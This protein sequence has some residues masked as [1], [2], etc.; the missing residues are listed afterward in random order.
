[1]KTII[2]ILIIGLAFF[3]GTGCGGGSGNDNAPADINGTWSGEGTITVDAQTTPITITMHFQRISGTAYHT[4]ILSKIP[5]YPQYV[6]ETTMYYV[7]SELRSTESAV[8]SGGSRVIDNRIETY[9]HSYINNTYVWL[10]I[11]LYR[12]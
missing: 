5:G 10:S 4:T 7:N 6:D 11:T 8:I 12:Q 9:T 3:F 1:M 2:L